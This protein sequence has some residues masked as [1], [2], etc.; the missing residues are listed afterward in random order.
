MEDVSIVIDI[1][2]ED[3]HEIDKPLLA[4][5]FHLIQAGMREPKEYVVTNTEVLK[6]KVKCISISDGPME[7]SLRKK[8]TRVIVLSNQDL[9]STNKVICLKVELDLRKPH[10][11][12][13]IV[14]ALK[15]YS[16]L[17]VNP[18]LTRYVDFDRLLIL[19]EQENSWWWSYV[20]KT[21]LFLVNIVF[22]E[23]KE[24]AFGHVLDVMEEYLMQLVWKARHPNLKPTATVEQIIAYLLGE[25]SN[26]DTVRDFKLMFI[27]DLTMELV[28]LQ[29]VEEYA[30]R[31]V[32]KNSFCIKDDSGHDKIVDLKLA[33]ILDW[34]LTIDFV[35]DF[36]GKTGIEFHIPI[37][38]DAVIL[39]NPSGK[40]KMVVYMAKYQ[41]RS[42]LS[43]DELKNLV[44]VITEEFLDQGERPLGYIEL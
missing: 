13:N 26:S 7:I 29:I 36:T 22:R 12:I 19:D 2:P 10:T 23:V 20:V 15:E 31:H 6:T 11:L 33:N 9:Q 17:W 43:K 21:S 1:K 16:W 42:K 18:K 35:N 28:R 4:A 39:D 27:E 44:M 30:R 37:N 32:S 41:E 25:K 14:K 24:R 5:I 40:C 34:N 8:D 38:A 3:V